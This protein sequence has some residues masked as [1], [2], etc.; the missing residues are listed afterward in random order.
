[1][2]T[3]RKDTPA[4][5]VKERLRVDEQGILFWLPFEG[6]LTAKQQA[7]NRR[8]AGTEAGRLN[9]EGYIH[10]TL[11]YQGRANRLKAHRIVWLLVHG[12]WPTRLIDHIN[13]VRHDNRPENLRDVGHDEN[14]WNKERSLPTGAQ[15]HKNIFRSR[16]MRDGRQI[17]L[18]TFKTAEE[19]S[20]AYFRAKTERGQANA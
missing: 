8:Y 5:F 2:K 19:A 4:S 7:W 3:T 9:E 10:V 14:E 16:I 13:R 6:S 1:M 12:D 15:K 17:S 20:A 18:G 11:N